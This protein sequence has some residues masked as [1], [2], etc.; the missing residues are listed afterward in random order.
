[1]TDPKIATVP[2]VITSVVPTI[3]ATQLEP[4]SEKECLRIGV[5]K[6][7]KAKPRLGIEDDREV[8]WNHPNFSVVD[9]GILLAFCKAEDITPSE[10]MARVCMAWFETNRVAIEAKAD[11]FVR[12]AMTVEDV[13]KKVEAAKRQ[14][15]RYMEQL[16][17]LVPPTDDAPAE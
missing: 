4:L 9:H 15:Q 14:L 10:L 12:A 16:G 17:L 8:V 2:V 13:Q 11:G 6:S 3:K 7:S 5:G 1:M